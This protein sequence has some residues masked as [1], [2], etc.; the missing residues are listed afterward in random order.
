VQKLWQRLFYEGEIMLTLKLKEA[1]EVLENLIEITDEDIKN[2]KIAD[3][4]AVFSNTSKKEE[5]AR[6]FYALKT[7]IDNILVQRNKPIDQIFTK[8]EEKLFDIFRDRLNKFHKLHKH[9][10]KLALSVA[11]FYNT[12][13]SKI[14]QENQID[15]NTTASFDSKL[16]LKA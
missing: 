2:I 4:K 3:H 15:Y 16:K 14:K 12:L 9:F 1:I 8:D 5:L 10:S 13:V 7:E 6:K 11:N